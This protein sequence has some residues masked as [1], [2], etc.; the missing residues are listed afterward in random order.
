MLGFFPHRFCKFV[1][2]LLILSKSF[3]KLTKPRTR[4]RCFSLILSMCITTKILTFQKNLHRTVVVTTHFPFLFFFFNY[5][6]TPLYSVFAETCHK[7][8]SMWWMVN[9]YSR[10]SE[11]KALPYPPV[12]RGTDSRF[13]L[14]KEFQ[15]CFLVL[16]ISCFELCWTHFLVPFGNAVVVFWCHWHLYIAFQM[17]TYMD[18]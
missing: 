8:S 14:C 16:R 6:F 13:R 9:G 18:K 10:V 7:K 12:T 2:F 17:A 1:L 4:C 5:S 11:P 15:E 3:S